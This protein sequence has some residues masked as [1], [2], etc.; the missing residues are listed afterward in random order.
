MRAGLVPAVSR[1]LYRLISAGPSRRWSH[2]S[3]TKE[4]RPVKKILVAATLAAFGAA[5]VLPAAAIV[6]SDGAFAAQKTAM[7][8]AKKKPAKK[9]KKPAKKNKM[10]A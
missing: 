1:D 8:T 2:V 7:K 6:S 5:V 9:H 3:I 4:R 10:A